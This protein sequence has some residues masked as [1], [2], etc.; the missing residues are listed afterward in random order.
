MFPDKG[1][2]LRESGWK[3][4]LSLQRQGYQKVLNMVLILIFSLLVF[5][6][7]TYYVFAVIFNFS[8]PFFKVFLSCNQHVPGVEEMAGGSDNHNKPRF[9]VVSV[10]V[11]CRLL[12]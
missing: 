3:K 2:W 4:P 8:F 11:E 1:K 5:S 10:F 9:D 7:L 12:I 6:V